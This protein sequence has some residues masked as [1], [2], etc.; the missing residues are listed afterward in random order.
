MAAREQLTGDDG[1]DPA[2][3]ASDDVPRHL[4]SLL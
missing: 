1:A 2:R 3:H 4:P